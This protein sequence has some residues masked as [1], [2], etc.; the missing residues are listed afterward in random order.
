MSKT[1][2]SDKTWLLLISLFIVSLIFWNTKFVYPVKIFVVFLHE[3]SHGIAAIISGGKI[4]SIKI[5]PQIGGVCNTYIPQNFFANLLVYSAG[6]LGSMFWGAFLLIMSS[7]TKFDRVMSVL[8]GVLLI[9]VSL[10]Y[11]RTTFGFFFCII[12]GI[13][14]IIIGFKLSEQ[15]NDTLLKFLGLVSCMY[16]VIDIKEDLIS[17]TVKES[18]AYKIAELFKLPRLSVL[19]GVFWAVIAI[20]VFIFAIKYSSGQG[21]ARISSVNNKKK[22]SKKSK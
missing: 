10:L 4:V 11:I 17:R 7:R 6:Y 16:A 5:S 14:M 21:P 20:V 13:A 3:L 2:N 9:I 15:I 19:I 18:D 8:L 12:F 22:A 1:S